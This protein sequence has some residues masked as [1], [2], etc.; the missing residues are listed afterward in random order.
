MDSD[1]TFGY[2]IIHKLI[3]QN[4]RKDSTNIKD[5]LLKRTFL[6]RGHPL[7]ESLSCG[8][9]Q[10]FRV[11]RTRHKFEFG[12]CQN[13]GARDEN[14]N[15]DKDALGN[16]RARARSESDVVRDRPLRRIYAC[17]QATTPKYNSD[18]GI[19]NTNRLNTNRV[20]HMFIGNGTTLMI[21]QAVLY[22]RRAHKYVQ[23]RFQG[24]GPGCCKQLVSTPAV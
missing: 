23:A 7:D 5:L 13:E 21:K 18:F 1:R 15:V 22:T 11:R 10:H 20:R 16:V 12:S 2:L 17:R 24:N 19:H 9:L 3:D 4:R 6:L 8:V 14:Q